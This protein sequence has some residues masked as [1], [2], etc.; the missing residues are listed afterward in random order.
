MSDYDFSS[1]NDKEFEDLSADLLT[2]HLGTR[3]KG[4]K[5][6]EMVV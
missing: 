4:L 5:L 6:V 2:C 1:L 3:L